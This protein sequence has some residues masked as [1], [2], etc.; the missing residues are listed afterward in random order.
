MLCP[1]RRAFPLVSGR[2]AFSKRLCDR[3][4]IEIPDDDRPR[5]NTQPAPEEV[6]EL[7]GQYISQKSG[8]VRGNAER[9]SENSREACPVVQPEQSPA[10]Q[11]AKRCHQEK[12]VGPGD[13]H[14]LEQRS[15]NAQRKKTRISKHYDGRDQKISGGGKK[16][17]S[18][19]RYAAAASSA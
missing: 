19:G 8:S 7:E 1:P 12:Q 11:S 13:F 18:T 5:A 14:S 2:N 9:G 15:A 3:R 4:L 17:S 16:Q 10:N 6:S